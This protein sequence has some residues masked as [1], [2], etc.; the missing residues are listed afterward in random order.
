M[1]MK[2]AS[3]IMALVVALV[4]VIALFPTMM[5]SAEVSPITIGE[6]VISDV[7]GDATL[8]SV[9][10]NYTTDTTVGDQ[11]TLL[12]TEVSSG[13]TYTTGTDPQPNNVVYIDQFDKSTSKEF[14]VDK[15]ALAGRTIYI[16][17]G[18]ML[19]DTATD[20][21]DQLMPGGVTLP[22]VTTDNLATVA[23]VKA[24]D[25]VYGVSDA[26][27]IVV[28]INGL[29]TPAMATTPN[30]YKVVVKGT[31]LR[32]NPVN[33]KFFGTPLLGTATLV[34]TDF[35]ITKEART[36]PNIMFGDVNN[37][38]GISIQDLNALKKRV[39]SSSNVLVN[40]DLFGDVDAN[41]AISIQDLNALKKKVA[42]SS[43][44]FPADQ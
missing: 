26:K 32:Y 2:K 9:T 34:P 15:A 19:V 40:G 42:S 35:T 36:V 11:M 44:V 30:D 12:V 17:M 23:T 3:K 13:V 39:A 10:V 8:S 33:T 25:N 16:K 29:I 27:L 4:M 28:D 14:V 20:P 21:K 24:Q 18:G 31:E 1:K 22:V 7:V 43:S 38:G 37:D 5:V 6:I 41:G